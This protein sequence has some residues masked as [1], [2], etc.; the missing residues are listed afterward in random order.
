MGA[1]Q[2]YSAVLCLHHAVRVGVKSL[3]R[4]GVDDKSRNDLTGSYIVVNL[5][6]ILRTVLLAC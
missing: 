2:G 6:D 5:G 3:R 4:G 1:P